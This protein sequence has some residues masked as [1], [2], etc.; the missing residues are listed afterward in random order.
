MNTDGEQDENQDTEVV[1]INAPEEK[2]SDSAAEERSTPIHTELQKTTASVNI[3][4]GIEVQH[5]ADEEDEVAVSTADAQVEESVSVTKGAAEDDSEPR[6]VNLGPESRT[7]NT[8][9]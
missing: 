3:D 2:H 8:D 5:D 7:V 4:Q 1:N 6:G 9:S